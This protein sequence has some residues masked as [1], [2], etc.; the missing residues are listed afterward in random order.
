MKREIYF[1][2]AL[3]SLAGGCSDSTSTK[4]ADSPNRQETKALN[5]IS[6]DKTKQVLASTI[7]KLLPRTI[8]KK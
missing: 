6:E 4:V 8:W 2:V 3:L 5:S 7:G 1:A